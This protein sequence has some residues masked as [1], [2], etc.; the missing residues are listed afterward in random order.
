[1]VG[2]FYAQMILTLIFNL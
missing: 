2:Q 1:M